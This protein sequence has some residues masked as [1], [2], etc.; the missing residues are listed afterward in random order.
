MKKF[1]WIIISILSAFLLSTSCSEDKDAIPEFDG[2]YLIKNGKIYIKSYAEKGMSY[3]PVPEESLPECILSI[4]DKHPEEI[5]AMVVF[6]GEYKGCHAYW[7][8][9]L[10]SSYFDPTLFSIDGEFDRDEL[11]WNTWKDIDYTK[12]TCIYFGEKYALYHRPV[13]IIN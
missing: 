6:E 2:S 10:G 8:H 1:T 11:P 12:L 5:K 9:Y 7:T 3:A 13:Y 4:F